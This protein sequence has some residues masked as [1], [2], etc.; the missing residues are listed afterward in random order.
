VVAAK[1]LVENEKKHTSGAKGQDIFGDL[2]HE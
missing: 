2:R 1:K